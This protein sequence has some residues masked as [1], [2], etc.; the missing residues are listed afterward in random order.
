MIERM[1]KPVIAITR[2]SD[3]RGDRPDESYRFYS[4]SV[5]RAGGTPMPVYYSDDLAMVSAILD[6]VQ[7]VLFSGGDD[8]DPALWGETWHPQAKRVDPRRQR[9][10]LELLRQ[11]EARRMPILGICLGCQLMNV[12]RGGSLIQFL[13]DVPREGAI[14][15][16]KLGDV[17]LRHDV[18]LEAGS[19]LAKAMAVTQLSVNT[20][21]KQAIGRPGRGL[22]VVARAGDGVVEAVEDG[23]LPLFMGVQWHPERISQEVEEARIFELL[24]GRSASA[25]LL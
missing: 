11:A 12:Y 7:G 1:D 5:E 2:D 18:T 23:S 3:G 19:G 8:L 20:Y 17:P 4:G 21:H 13:P 15:H 22:S 6:R 16:R 14:E 25:R 10:E 24:V 9:F